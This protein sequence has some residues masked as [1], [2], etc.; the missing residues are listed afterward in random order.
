MGAEQENQRKRLLWIKG[1]CSNSGSGP[2]SIDN[3]GAGIK[4]GKN[5]KVESSGPGEQRKLRLENGI[6]G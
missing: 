3:G 4:L 5:G 1:G 2:G 6:A